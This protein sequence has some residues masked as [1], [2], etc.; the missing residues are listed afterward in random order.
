MRAR[1][2]RK[3]QNHGALTFTERRAAERHAHSFRKS[4]ADDGNEN[5]RRML[6][7]SFGLQPWQPQ[8]RTFALSFFAF[9]AQ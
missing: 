1:T 6:C 7:S 5:K 9:W 2:L 8:G 4:K 3:Q